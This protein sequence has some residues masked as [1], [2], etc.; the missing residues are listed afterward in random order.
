MF[1]YF[2]L[3]LAVSV[4]D[5]SRSSTA[6]LLQVP[7]GS[8]SLQ[9]KIPDLRSRQRAHPDNHINLAGSLFFFDLCPAVAST[10]EPKGAGKR[11]VSREGVEVMQAFYDVNRGLDPSPAQLNVM[12]KQIRAL[13]NNDHFTITHLK[14]WFARKKEKEKKTKADRILNELEQQNRDAT[15]NPAYLSL[16]KGVIDSLNELFSHAVR[17]EKPEARPYL[18]DCWTASY[19]GRE[20]ATAADIRAWIAAAEAAHSSP[21]GPLRVN[22]SMRRDSAYDYGM[23]TPS[24]TTSPEPQPR[25]P[26]SA[27][28]AHNLSHGRRRFSPSASHYRARPYEPPTPTSRAASL[29]LKSEPAQSPVMSASYIPPSPYTPPLPAPR[30]VAPLPPPGLVLL[31]AVKEAMEEERRN[32]AP[33]AHP[34]NAQEMINLLQPLEQPMHAFLNSLSHPSWDPCKLLSQGDRHSLVL[35]GPF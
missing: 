17:E 26:A 12:I 20:G 5:F 22:V 4:Q 14:D 2:A 15:R 16:T 27:A 29:S 11:R 31:T 28:S 6:G 7:G 34:K 30:A 1:F 10:S 33:R 8:I 25:P 32:P 19:T 18:H 21:T 3:I 13:P 24:D 9:L 23:P 35:N